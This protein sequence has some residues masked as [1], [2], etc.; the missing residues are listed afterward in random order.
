MCVGDYVADLDVAAAAVEGRDE[1]PGTFGG[2]GRDHGYADGV[3]Y[4]ADVA[5]EDVGDEDEL[6]EG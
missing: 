5:V 1:D 6:A 2:D 4:A 3:G